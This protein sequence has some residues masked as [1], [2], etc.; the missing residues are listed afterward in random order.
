MRKAL[1]LADVKRELRKHLQKNYRNNQ[2]A[3]ADDL[4]MNRNNVH[5]ALKDGTLV[6]KS[7]MD[8]MGIE[9]DV[10]TYRWKK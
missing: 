8:A 4:N 1:T 7:M 9:K 3:L 10:T 2:S 6:P 5:I